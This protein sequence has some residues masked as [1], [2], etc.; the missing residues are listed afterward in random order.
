MQSTKARVRLTMTDDDTAD[1]YRR[2][3]H[4]K[5]MNEALNDGGNPLQNKIP[6]FDELMAAW[7]AEFDAL[8]PDAI[9]RYREG[10][11]F[12]QIA[13]EFDLTARQVQV[14]VLGLIRQTDP[15][16]AASDDQL[17]DPAQL[18]P[19]AIRRFRDGVTIEQIMAEWRSASR[20]RR[21]DDGITGGGRGEE[22]HTPEGA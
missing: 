7:V 13:D 10:G 9:Q 14:M 17:A 4:Y 1:I 15:P 18:P 19:Y 8:P 11:T 5:N 21:T 22:P 2:G 16:Q 6:P 20:A 12:T 3:R